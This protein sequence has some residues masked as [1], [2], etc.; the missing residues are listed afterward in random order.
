[1]FTMVQWIY[2][3]IRQ[4]KFKILFACIVIPFFLTHVTFSQWRLR[5]WHLFCIEFGGPT[6]E[7]Q[8][9]SSQSAWHLWQN[10]WICCAV[11]P[12]QWE[13]LF[14]FNLLNFFG[15]FIICLQ[16]IFSS[17][18][19]HKL[20]KILNMNLALENIH[21]G[22]ITSSLDVLLYGC[23]VKNRIWL[24]VILEYDWTPR[25]FC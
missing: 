17:W 14:T 9:L 4:S 21:E 12:F 5:I 22:I 6:G 11:F 7:C 1:M 16:S 8:H 24:P 10:F 20:L 15:Y 23:G 13:P 18:K 19:G 3:C 25:Y 2:P